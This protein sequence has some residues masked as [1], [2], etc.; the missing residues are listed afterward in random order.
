[1]PL[2]AE[3]DKWKKISYVFLG[4]LVVPYTIFTMI[5][6]FQHGQCRSGAAKAATAACGAAPPPSC[7]GPARMTR[8]VRWPTRRMTLW[9]VRAM[10]GAPA[11]RGLRTHVSTLCHA[12]TSTSGLRTRTS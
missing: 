4:G 7:P 8:V 6:H 2:T 3:T 5:R 9:L 10:S 11:A 1:M 12:A